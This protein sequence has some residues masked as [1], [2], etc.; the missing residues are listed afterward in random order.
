MPGSKG[1]GDAEATHRVNARTQEP[2]RDVAE[3]P[4]PCEADE[5]AVGA[6]EGEAEPPWL[7]L[8]ER[9]A[10]LPP[11]DLATRARHEKGRTGIVRLESCPV[12][13][14]GGAGAEPRGSLPQV[15]SRRVPSCRSVPKIQ[16]AR[17]GCW[18]DI[19]ASSD[20]P[21]HVRSSDRTVPA[22]RK[23]SLPTRRDGCAMRVSVPGRGM[24]PSCSR[25][26]TIALQILAV[27]GAVVTSGAGRGEPAPRPAGTPQNT[28]PLPSTTPAHSRRS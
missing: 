15:Q 13:A 19:S 11:P 25:P 4:P 8:R 5:P 10:P 2:P 17:S 1:S 7:P 12:H 16:D 18:T 22:T 24:A 9:I 21:G 6:L 27:P 14:T 26:P 3:E 28:R 23:T 20:H